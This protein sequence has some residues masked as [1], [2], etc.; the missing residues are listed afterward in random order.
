MA[1]TSG[2]RLG[3][4]EILT[5]LGAGGM[6]EVYRA[7]DTRLRRTVAIKILPDEIASHAERRARILAEARAAAALNHPGITTIYE[8]GEE[9]DQIFIVMELVSGKTIRAILSE[10][11]V[12]S[13]VLLRL[14]AHVAEALAAAHAHGVIP[15]GSKPEELVFQPEGRVKL[16]DFGIAS[17]MA[18]ETATLTRTGSTASCLPEVQCGGATA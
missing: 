3:S 2:T 5:P 13:R 6:G 12:E 7:R 9:G 4:Y 1:L 10:G 8:V 15:G 11:P 18:V 14:G 16:L 17:Q